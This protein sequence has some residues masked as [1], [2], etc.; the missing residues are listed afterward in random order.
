MKLCTKHAAVGVVLLVWLYLWTEQAFYGGEGERLEAL[1]STTVRVLEQHDV[2]HWAAGGNFFG[3][4]LDRGLPPGDFDADLM[5]TLESAARIRAAN[6]TAHGLLCYEGFGGFRVKTARLS[7]LRVDLFVR[8][9]QDGVLRYGW[10]PMDKMY[11]KALLPVQLVFPLRRLPMDG[12]MRGMYAP[13][14]PHEALTFEYGAYT[15][16]PPRTWRSMGVGFV[17]RYV[18]SPLIPL[19]SF[20]SPPMP[21]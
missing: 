21:Y 7:A 13:H 6:W 12:D 8:R 2:T 4:Y 19:A 3:A 1:L 16:H 5:V 11:K 14:R 17:E 9:V 18:W 10:S 20:F 15:R